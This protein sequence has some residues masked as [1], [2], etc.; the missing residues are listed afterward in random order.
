VIRHLFLG[1]TGL[2]RPASVFSRIDDDDDDDDE[3][4][5]YLFIV[6]LSGLLLRTR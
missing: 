3:V 5:R 1:Y 4:C 6:S 2:S